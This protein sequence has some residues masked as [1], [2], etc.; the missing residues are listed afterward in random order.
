MFGDPAVVAAFENAAFREMLGN[1]ELVKRSPTRTW[2]GLSR[3]KI[4]MA[5]QDE[6]GAQN[7]RNGAEPSGL[8][9]S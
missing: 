1:G 4:A 2:R 7:Q 6:V 9:F 8:T 5:L 3:S